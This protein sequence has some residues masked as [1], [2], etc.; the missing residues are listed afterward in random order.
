ML[1]LSEY[2]VFLKEK[3]RNIQKSRFFL[4]IM[5]IVIQADL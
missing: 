5:E 2:M 3:L 1:A 4:N